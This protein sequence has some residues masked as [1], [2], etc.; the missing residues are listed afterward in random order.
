ML[1]VRNKL[2]ILFYNFSLIFK[3]KLTSNKNFIIWGRSPYLEYGP[4]IRTRRLKKIIE[5]ES[6]NKVFIYMQSNLYSWCQ[7][8]INKNHLQSKWHIHK[9]I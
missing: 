3:Y 7:I 1:N 2:D 6:I 4:G 9:K 5:K 8:I